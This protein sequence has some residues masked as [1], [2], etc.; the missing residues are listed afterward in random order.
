MGGWGSL[1]N[2]KL[3]THHEDLKNVMPALELEKQVKS[4]FPT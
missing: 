3:K 2:L 1:F 4:I